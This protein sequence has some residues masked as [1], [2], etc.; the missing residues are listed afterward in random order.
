MARLT[1]VTHLR[2]LPAWP[3]PNNGGTVM[4]YCHLTQYGINFNNGFGPLPGDKIRSRV[5]AVG[6]LGTSCGGGGGCSA[7][8]GLNISNIT[9]TT[10]TAAWNAVSGATSYKFEYKNLLI[11]TGR[12]LQ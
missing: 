9:S 11:Q 7:P 8:T 2:K 4:S 12:K 10:A 3:P 5:A 1:I 6:C